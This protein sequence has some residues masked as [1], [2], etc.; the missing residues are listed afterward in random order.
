MVDKYGL[1]I[2]TRVVEL[3]QVWHNVA[4]Q[5]HRKGIY[6]HLHIAIVELGQGCDPIFDDL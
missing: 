3:D 6:Q 5:E 2:V 1:E 4:G